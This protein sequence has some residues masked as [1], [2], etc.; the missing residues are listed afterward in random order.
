MCFDVG[1]S[2]QGTHYT[3]WATALFDKINLREKAH[4]MPDNENVYWG[5]HSSASA[6]NI[7]AQ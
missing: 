6:G 2:E 1:H 4:E 3:S 7:W 5:T